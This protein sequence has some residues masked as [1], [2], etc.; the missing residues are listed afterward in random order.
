MDIKASAKEELYR[1]ASALACITVAYNLVEGIVSAWFGFDDDSLA[2]FGFGLDSFVEVVSGAGIWHMVR[3][4]RSNRQ[5]ERDR[6]ERT[7]LRITG[8]CFYLL[9]A[10]L[11]VSGAYDIYHGHAPKTTFWGIVVSCVSILSMWLLIHYK[12]K[13]GRALESKAIMADAACTRVCLYL[14]GILLAFS[15]GYRFTGIG[16]LDSAGALGISWFCYKEG[17]EALEKAVGLTCSCSC[18]CKN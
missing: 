2:L 1:L 11:L 17:K 15:V 14:S 16:W 18:G 4:Q 9:A 3:R 8:Y 6:F 5:E 12:V 7:A 10:G 13:A